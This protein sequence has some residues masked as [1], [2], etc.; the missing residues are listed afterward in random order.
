MTFLDI[1][2]FLTIVVG[3]LV[4]LFVYFQ[5]APVLSLQITPTWTD[6]HKHL[7]LVR[8]E[9]ENKSRVRL[10]DPK[11]MIQILQYTI[12]PGGSLSNW[13]PFDKNDE[14]LKKEQPIEW[15]DPEIIF[16]STKQIF[17]GEKIVNEQIYHVSN[18]TAIIHIGLQ[19]GMRLG[20]WGRLITGKKENWRQTMTC[21]AVKYEEETAI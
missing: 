21:F 1:F 20:I 4:T 14:H 19:V 6:P 11:G 16:E 5:L 10:L 9:I 15:H 18:K 7:L 17:P 13:V 8:F 3:G 2:T 12:Q